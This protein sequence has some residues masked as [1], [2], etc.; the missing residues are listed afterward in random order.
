MPLAFPEIMLGLNQTI[1]FGL[2]MVM[3]TGFI[4]GNDRLLVV[5]VRR[6]RRAMCGP[7]IRHELDERDR[8]GR[9]RLDDCKQL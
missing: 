5:P 4:G 7:A 3:I 8:Y 6:V 1:M 9:G 2:F